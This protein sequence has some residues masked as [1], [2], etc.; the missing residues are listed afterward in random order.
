MVAAELALEEHLKLYQQDTAVLP[1]K[2]V[3]VYPSLV[4]ALATLAAKALSLAKATEGDL[5]HLLDDLGSQ[6]LNVIGDELDGPSVFHGAA[7]LQALVLRLPAPTHTLTHQAGGR[8][9]L[10]SE[11]VRIIEQGFYC[12]TIVAS[13]CIEHRAHEVRAGYLRWGHFR[14]SYIKA[15]LVSRRCCH[16]WVSSGGDRNVFRFR[17]MFLFCSQ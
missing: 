7:C 5:G 17:I 4:L 16:G 12:S 1:F 9:E 10:V 6:P 15:Q 8:V 3:S 2:L 13:I 11:E 14:L